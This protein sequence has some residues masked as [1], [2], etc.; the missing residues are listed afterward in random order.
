MVIGLIVGV[1]CFL[2]SSAAAVPGVCNFLRVTQK[3]GNTYNLLVC[4]S[5]TRRKLQTPGNAEEHNWFVVV[6]RLCHACHL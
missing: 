6:C 2:C 3:T 5:V 4:G 1:L